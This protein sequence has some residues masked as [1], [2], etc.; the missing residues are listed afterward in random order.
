MKCLSYVILLFAFSIGAFGGELT[1]GFTRQGLTKPIGITSEADIA[2]LR[3]M[4]WNGKPPSNSYDT[5]KLKQ[6]LAAAV[7]EDPIA[8]MAMNLFT[9]C[10]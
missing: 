2:D 9:K 10:T 6:R 1:E 7:N 8:T 3:D 5:T 4:Y